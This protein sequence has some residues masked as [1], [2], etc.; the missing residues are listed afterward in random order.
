MR[1]QIDVPSLQPYNLSLTVDGVT[2]GA[3]ALPHPDALHAKIARLHAVLRDMGRVAVALSGGVDSSYLTAAAADA[4]GPDRVLAL[5]ADSPLFPRSELQ[6]ARAVAKQLGVRH[7]IVPMDDLANPRVLANPTDRCYH[8]KRARFEALLHLLERAEKA[9]LVHGENA[10]DL[11]AY[12]PGSR[13]AGELGVRAPL[14]EAGL[15]KAEIRELARQRGLPNWDAPAAGCLATRF[16]Y[17]VPL[18]AEGLRRVECAEERLRRLLD[19]VQLRVR[20]HFPVA[21][22]EVAEARLAEVAQEPLRSRIAGALH[23]CGYGYVTLDLEGYRS[24]SFD[25]Q[26]VHRERAQEQPH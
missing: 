26:S 7:R 20:D 22:L 1:V 4:L 12:R 11:Q 2:H 3:G 21:R 9:A 15:G 6:T 24:G 18:S 25:D 23:E 13:A 10:D 5:T 17:G 16:P 8:C 14:A 19:G